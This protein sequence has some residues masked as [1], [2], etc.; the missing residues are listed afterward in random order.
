MLTSA[1]SWLDKMREGGTSATVQVQGPMRDSDTPEWVA[2][3]DCA[4]QC[5]IAELAAVSYCDRRLV[6]LEIAHDRG[7]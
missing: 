4:P 3:P 6:N 2:E 1:A 5:T 7:S